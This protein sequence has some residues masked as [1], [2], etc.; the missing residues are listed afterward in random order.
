[1]SIVCWGLLG[2]LVVVLLFY[3]L[4]KRE[5]ALLQRYLTENLQQQDLRIVNIQ[6]FDPS[7]EG[8]GHS[9]NKL[10]LKMKE[11]EI[12]HAESD[13]KRMKMISNISHDM[14]TP[15]TSILGFAQLLRKS[16]GSAEKQQ[17]YISMIEDRTQAIS[18]MLK[19]FFTLTILEEEN[20]ETTLEAID[21]K[22]LV[23]SADKAFKAAYEKKGLQL[24]LICGE[25]ASKVIGS[26]LMV[27][28]ILE[29]LYS[30]A[31]KYSEGDVEARLLDKDEY[32][33]FEICNPTHKVTQE[34]IAQLFDRFYTVD[35]SRSN[36][37][38][39][40]GLGLAISAKLADRLGGKLT[41]ELKGHRISFYLKLKSLI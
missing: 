1:M 40:S 13:K 28:R 12:A 3:L 18:R 30:N 24:K 34:N 2:L 4:L 33:V 14:R 17:E 38:S 16:P 35:I 6:L 20:R 11:S 8:L 22:E 9:I 19:D 5:I 29:N 41:C 39:G 37:N 10:I 7:L 26:S 21:L 25:E 31:L 32:K 23:S 15:L 27:E 36:E